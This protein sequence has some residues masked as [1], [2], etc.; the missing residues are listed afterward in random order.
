MDE[1]GCAD[2]TYRRGDFIAGGPERCGGYTDDPAPSTRSC[3]RTTPLPHRGVAHILINTLN[4]TV[5]DAPRIPNERSTPRDPRGHRRRG[6]RLAH[7]PR[8]R[9]RRPLHHRWRAGDHRAHGCAQTR[10]V[11]AARRRTHTRAANHP[12]PDEITSYRWGGPDSKK[13]LIKVDP[14]VVVEVTADAA[15]QAGQ[16]RHG[17]RYV[18]VRADLNPNDL[19]TAPHRS[20]VD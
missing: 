6:P 2:L 10:A 7:P 9:H 12:W 17:M 5:R 16:L 19:P 20:Q 13:P 11:G 18:R 15:T 14:T 1:S 8:G 3:G 4:T